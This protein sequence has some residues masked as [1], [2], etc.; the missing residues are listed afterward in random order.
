MPEGATVY[1]AT[2]PIAT[3]SAG[4]IYRGYV[5]FIGVAHRHGGIFDPEV[6][7]IIGASFGGRPHFPLGRQPGATDRDLGSTLL[8]RRRP[9]LAAGVFRRSESLL[10]VWSAS[11]SRCSLLHP[12]AANAIAITPGTRSRA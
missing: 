9:T 12:V 11:R 5:R 2:V 1:P 4:Q 6:A 10:V 8:G 3:M 7:A